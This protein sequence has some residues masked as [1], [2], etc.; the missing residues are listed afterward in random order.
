MPNEMQY[1]NL[2]MAAN[3]PEMFNEMSPFVTN[4]P[5]YMRLRE[6]HCIDPAEPVSAGG[7]DDG[8]DDGLLNGWLPT[9]IRLREYDVSVQ[10][11]C[12]G[13]PRYLAIIGDSQCLR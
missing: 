11:P 1:H 13:P 8:I 2:V 4:G 9:G 7:S 5:I 12:K 10:I 3:V 6:H